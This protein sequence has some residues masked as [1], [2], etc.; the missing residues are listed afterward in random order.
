[1]QKKTKKTQNN[2]GESISKLLKNQ[3][4]QLVEIFDDRIK[5]VTEQYGDIKNTLK[6]HTET[7]K[8]HSEQIANLLMDTTELKY[9]VKQ[10][11]L[12][13]KIDLQNK[14]DKKHFVDLDQRIRKLEKK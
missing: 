3:T 14:V 12:D 1:M 10:I 8:S 4:E 13:I 6:F 7:L 11:K 5:V 9:D 2:G